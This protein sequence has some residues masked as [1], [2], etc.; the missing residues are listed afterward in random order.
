M[1]LSRARL[2]ARQ[3]APCILALATALLAFALARPSQAT[4]A[5]GDVNCD[6]VVTS[7]DAA[8]LLQLSAGLVDDLAC[9]AKA[10]ATQDGSV[11]SRDAALVLQH[12]AGLIDLGPAPPAPTPPG[13]AEPPTVLVEVAAGGGHACSLTSDGRVLCWGLSDSGQLGD[14]TMTGDTAQPAPREVCADA[15]CVAPLSNAV[16]LTAGTHHVCVVTNSGAAM[17]WGDN[18]FGQLGDESEDDRAAPQVVVGLAQ[19]VA[20]IEAGAFHTCAVTTA[21]GVL[22]WGSNVS[23]QLGDGT[24]VSRSAPTQ[25]I[26]LESGISAIA[27]GGYHTCALTDGAAVLCWG[28]G[29]HGQIGDGD[30]QNRTE[31]VAVSG[32]QSSVVALT[33]GLWHTCAL[34]DDGAATCW[35]RNNA[36][37]VGDGTTTNRTTP[38]GVTGLTGSVAA[39]DGGSDYTCAALTAGGARC[40]GDNTFGQLGDGATTER[41]APAEVLQLDGVLASISAGEWHTCALAG[42]NEVSCWG[43]NLWGQLGTEDVPDQCESERFP[44]PVPCQSTPA[45]VPGLGD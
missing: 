32:L 41:H 21:G 33:G 26:G 13:T 1:R 14:G 6:G 39:I 2:P 7:I 17:C 5:P 11:D 42:A 19:D 18:A 20:A 15:A 30:T 27:M 35:G 16:Q 22:C 9:D 28:D 29:L 24:N 44:E 34:T 8:L 37:Q 40:W 45:V 23:S 10:D 25:V 3:A 31:P 38:V 43:M 4:S 12:V 36:G